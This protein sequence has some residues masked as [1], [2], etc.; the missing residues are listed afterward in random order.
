MGVND[1]AQ[2]LQRVEA[3]LRRRP[4]T[5]LHDDAPATARWEGGMRMVASHPSGLQ[6]LTDMPGELGG[7]GDQVSPGWLFRAGMASCT[8]TRIAMAA[9]TAGI[10]LQTL[11]LRVSS[12]SDTRGL[13]GL[14]DE[15]GA[16]I[17]ASPQNVELLVRIAAK[18]VS[19]ERLRALVEGSYAQSPVPCAVQD[20]VPVALRIKVET[21]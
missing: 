1:I 16:A 4:E 8:A 3:V 17:R 5:G 20:A 21:D 9:A 18:G 11:E 19:A 15:D 13:L 10:E 12:R 7:T 14:P 6:V 2:A